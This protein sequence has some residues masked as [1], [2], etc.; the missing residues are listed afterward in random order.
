MWLYCST[1]KIRSLMSTLYAPDHKKLIWSG[2]ITKVS[3]S[4]LQTYSY[5]TAFGDHCC[6]TVL[7]QAVSLVRTKCLCGTSCE[8]VPG[9]VAETGRDTSLVLWG[10]S[11]FWASRQETT[12]VWTQPLCERCPGSSAKPSAR[13][14]LQCQSPWSTACLASLGAHSWAA[15]QLWTSTWLHTGL[16]AS[17]LRSCPSFSSF[18]VVA[19]FVCCNTEPPQQPA[20]LQSSLRL[21]CFPYPKHWAGLVRVHPLPAW[22]KACLPAAV[23]HSC[24]SPGSV[25]L[26]VCQQPPSTDPKQKSVLRRGWGFTPLTGHKEMQNTWIKHWGC[27]AFCW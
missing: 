10:S 26:L 13:R 18:M 27:S 4:P 5:F 23:V 22:C 20:G 2:E 6:T 21:W 3:I 25:S 24:A 9:R 1:D 12:T 11:F 15:Y 16:L 8:W 19:T 14:Q 7:L 17:S